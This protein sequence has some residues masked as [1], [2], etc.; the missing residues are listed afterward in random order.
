MEM[1]RAVEAK[2]LSQGNKKTVDTPVIICVSLAIVR[3][4]FLI[5]L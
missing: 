4:F 3:R 2:L 1:A 5:L